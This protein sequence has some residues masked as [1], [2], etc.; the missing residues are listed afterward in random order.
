MKGK[1]YNHDGILI[2]ETW[3]FIR[4]KIKNKTTN[5]FWKAIFFRTKNSDILYFAM[6]GKQ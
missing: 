6:K 3:D 2:L 1:Q 5:V 4:H